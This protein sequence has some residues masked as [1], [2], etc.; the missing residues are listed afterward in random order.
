MTQYCACTGKWLLSLSL[1]PVPEASP[2]GS[3][4]E[5]AQQFAA[6]LARRYRVRS[7]ACRQQIMLRG[8]QHRHALRYAG[9][10]RG[11]KS[12]LVSV[13]RWLGLRDV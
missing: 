13:H 6:A 7:L 5:Q 10:S 11:L 9:S 12:A 4:L 1:P 3:A 8:L 2:W